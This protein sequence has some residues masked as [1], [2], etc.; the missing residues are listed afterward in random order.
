MARPSVRSRLVDGAGGQ[1][2]GSHCTFGESVR[3]SAHS[4][5]IYPCTLHLVPC[6][7]P[8][9][10]F[11]RRPCPAARAIARSRHRRRGAWSGD[12]GSTAT[13]PT[14]RA[15]GGP[16]RRE[17]SVVLGFRACLVCLSRG[18]R[19]PPSRRRST[20]AMPPAGPECA[21][22]GITK[23]VTLHAAR[24]P[25]RSAAPSSS[26]SS[27]ASRRPRRRRGFVIRS[28]VRSST[29]A[30]SRMAQERS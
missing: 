6:T 28:R 18:G 25:A 8:L 1:R 13:I 5:D 22:S 2:A 24:R 14:R 19:V 15:V 30:T 23:R 27:H 11:R 12:E 16:A 10:L 21:P 29:A 20:C 17:G 26:A 9:C 3:G 4:S 7:W